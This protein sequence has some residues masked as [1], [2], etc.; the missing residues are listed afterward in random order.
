[1]GISAQKSEYPI[2]NMKFRM[3]KASVLHDWLGSK[4]ATKRSSLLVR[5]SFDILRFDIGY[6]TFA[7]QSGQGLCG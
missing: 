3:M 5:H 2:S 4:I 7:F 1:M 6:S